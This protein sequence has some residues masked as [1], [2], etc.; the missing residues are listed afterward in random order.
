MPWQVTWSGR[1]DVA[2]KK[3]PGRGHLWEG[4][5]KDT[6]G[7]PGQKAGANESETG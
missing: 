5:G 4:N 3:E 2:C 7:I 6:T 1:S